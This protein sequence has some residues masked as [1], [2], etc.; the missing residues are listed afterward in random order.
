MLLIAALMAS[1]ALAIDAMLPA[2]P[3]IGEALDVAEEN[4]RQLVITFYMLGFGVAQ[5]AYGPLADRFGRKRLLLGCMLGLCR[6]RLALRRWPAAS[7][8]CSRRGC[9]TAWRRRDAGAGRRHRPRPLPGLGDGADH[10]DRDDH[11]HDRA[12]ARAG[13]SA[14]C[15]SRSAAGAAIFLGARRLRASILA[16]WAV[17][18]LPET[19]APEHRR[20]LSVRDYRRGGEGDAQQPRVGRQH[21]RHDADLR[22]AARLSSIRSSRSSSTSSTGPSCS[23]SIFACIAG[24]MA[25]SVLAEFAAGR[26]ASARAGCC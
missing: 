3:A 16:V 19:L 4:R 14:S 6:L 7:R 25:I 10:V 15:C 11:L 12:G 18:R 20:P 21:A 5:L 23:A 24:P 9:C 8:C 2:L 22:R 17:L 1:N 13:A 26:C